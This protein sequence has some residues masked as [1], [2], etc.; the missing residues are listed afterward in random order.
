MSLRGITLHSWRRF[1]ELEIDFDEHLTVIT[2]VNNSGKS[3]FLAA[4]N[5]LLS[6]PTALVS[7]VTVPTHSQLSVGETITVGEV[8]YRSGGT[9]ELCTPASTPHDLPVARSTATTRGMLIDTH[10]DW[11]RGHGV[12]ITSEQ[13]AGYTELMRRVLPDAMFADVL[14]ALR[15]EGPDRL[16][17]PRRLGGIRAL[18]GTLWHL[19]VLTSGSGNESAVV[20]IDEPELHL[21]PAVQREIVPRLFAA[22]P[23]A[24]LV[25]ATHSPFIV[26]ADPTAQTYVLT[27]SDDRRITAYRAEDQAA[28]GTANDV[29]REG[30]GVPSTLPVWVERKL[31]NLAQHLLDDDLDTKQPIDEL[32]GQL[33]DMGLQQYAP[34]ILARVLAARRAAHD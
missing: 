18:L 21:H 20:L 5:V 31:A 7:K 4:L 33:S 28:H 27:E 9:I 26:S 19:Y 14:P 30:L 11:P 23:D 29:L 24:Q 13:W 10:G 3:S 34:E 2:G 15:R 8:R 16:T 22:A 25:V 1:G 17:F 32:Y 12:P 6:P